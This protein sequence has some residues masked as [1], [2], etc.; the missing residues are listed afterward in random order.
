MLENREFLVCFGPYSVDL[1]THELRKDSLKLRLVG[2]PFEILT[3]LL[4]RPGELVTRE[5]LRD[6]LWAG[7]TF[8]D[9]DHGLNAAVNKLREALC[10]SA[11]N[12][13]YVETLPR[14]GYRFIGTIEKPEVKTPPLDEVKLTITEPTSPNG[15]AGQTERVRSEA[16]AKRG[17]AWRSRTYLAAA[18]VVGLIFLGSA[19]VVKMRFSSKA[20]E[21]FAPARISALTKPE[22]AAGD[23]AFSPDGKTIA[24]YRQGNAAGESGI[25][26]QQIGSNQTK[27]LSSSEKDCCPVWSPDGKAIA[28]SRYVNKNFAVFVVPASG[29]MEQR[30]EIPGADAQ[31]GLLDWA[32]DGEAI[33]LSA[34][35][36]LS[37]LSLKNPELRRLTQPSPLTQDWGPSFSADGKQ[38]LFARSSEMGFP[39]E[40]L[41]IPAAGGEATVVATEPARL[42][43]APRWSADGKSV[44]FS[45][46][47]G[48]KPALW[49]VAVEK[50]EAAV[51]FHDSGSHPAISRSGN[52][53]AYQRETRGLSIWQME[54]S[55]GDAAKARVLIPITS[56]TDQGP[57][58]QFS[59]DGKK[60]AYMSDRSGAMEIWVSDSDGGNST[61]VSAIGNA[62]TPRWSPDSKSIVF[63]GSR[64]DGAG[65]YAI[66]LGGG[67]PRL[68][69]PDQS[70]NRCPSWSRDGKWIYFASS[71][72][73]SWQVWKVPSA[74][75][76]AVQ[77]T[78]RGGHAPLESADGKFIYYA[79]TPYANPEIWQVHVTGGKESIVSPL[80]RPPSWASWAVVD[81]GILY[82]EPSGQ[83][84]P[85][86]NLFDPVSRRIQKLGIL[87]VVPFW[88]TATKDGRTVAFD[89]PG[90]Q[91]A[92]VML[93]EN[94]R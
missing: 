62:G 82:A 55:E 47:R 44:I 1:Q 93:I 78:T 88:L 51:Q 75:G 87:D 70:E 57:G 66:E 72:S 77:V 3:M 32:P 5:Q 80:V 48:G 13:K 18:I 76:A 25:F 36:G 58:P 85:V 10:D 68:L 14:R 20:A 49:R 12:P 28:F 42:R 17:K 61:Q 30:L 7:D 52:R 81:R 19:L 73:G 65:I 64:R 24:F 34:G 86:L 15:A 22:D 27:Q 38:I 71:R 8:V 84:A 79:K 6:R 91:Q 45:S 74:G 60:I 50:R 23:P 83:G 31:M 37:L 67:A 39:E 29:G 16:E 35:S 53:L 54:L 41:T 9:F 90:W 4:S 11:E 26:V 2:Q 63:D 46:D 92:Q 59:P 40:I 21:A 94:F 89:K 56:Q 69:T 43:G 33:A